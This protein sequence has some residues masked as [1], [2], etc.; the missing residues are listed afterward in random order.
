MAAKSNTR[1]AIAKQTCMTRAF[2]VSMA[3]LS[4]AAAGACSAEGVR[5]LGTGRWAEMSNT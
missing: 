1:E 2:V 4:L 5:G 3:S